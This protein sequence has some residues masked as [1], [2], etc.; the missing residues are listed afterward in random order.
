[1]MTRTWLAYWRDGCIGQ[2]PAHF[3]GD[4]GNVFVYRGKTLSLLGRRGADGEH[5]LGHQPETQVTH[6]ILIHNQG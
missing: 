4:H 5:Q 6:A 2:E 3:G 1:M